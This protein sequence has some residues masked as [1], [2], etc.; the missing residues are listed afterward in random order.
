MIFVFPDDGNISSKKKAQKQFVKLSGISSSKLVKLLF[1]LENGDKSTARSASHQSE[2]SDFIE[3]EISAFVA[4][5]QSERISGVVELL[6]ARVRA[7]CNYPYLEVST[8]SE[9][10]A[11]T[12]EQ[13]LLTFVEACNFL[14]I[15]CRELN[16]IKKKAQKNL[17]LDEVECQGNYFIYAE[18]LRM[19]R[20][21][22]ILTP[23]LVHKLYK[24]IKQ[25]RSL[26]NLMYKEIEIPSNK[27]H[28]INGFKEALFFCIVRLLETNDK[29]NR[30]YTDKFEELLNK[31]STILQSQEEKLAIEVI[32][33]NLSTY[34][35]ECRPTGY[36]VVFCVTCE[37]KGAD[38]EIKKVEEVFGNS[39][40]YTVKTEINPTMETLDSYREEFSRLKY[41]FYDSLVVWFMC[42][43]NMKEIA[44]G[45]KE[46]H[47]KKGII[48][49][50]CKLENF[51]K[52][53]KVFFM[54]SC[55]GENPIPIKNSGKNTKYLEGLICY[56][57]NKPV[58]FIMP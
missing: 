50:F 10:L 58:P 9:Y 5:L 57:E 18:N 23:D 54:A 35:I 47:D 25:D 15:D 11:L 26:A 1:L 2:K 40:G 33:N 34:P 13:D 21:C 12:E 20:I 38:A 4:F 28:Q 29:H 41:K 19:S 17:C 32:L 56:Y 3:Q 49:S 24:I 39:L 6:E 52:K 48:D 42:H 36:C 53:P 51:R 27:L 7:L 45:D 31:L 55:Q 22:D 8:G 14:N 46:M 16:A 37:R 30:I 43:G 44:L